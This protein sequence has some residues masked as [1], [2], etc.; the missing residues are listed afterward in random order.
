[1]ISKQRLV[2]LASPDINI[3]HL[4]TSS[5]KLY[6]AIKNLGD[7]SK[8]LINESFPPP[9]QTGY[10]ERFRILG[11]PA[12]NQSNVSLSYNHVIMPIDPT[13]YWTFTQINLIACYFTC[14]IVGTGS[15]TYFDI[16]VSQQKGTTAWKSLF[17]FGMSPNLPI[18]VTSTHNVQ[19]AIGQ[20]FQD[21]LLRIDTLN[22]DG[23]IADFELALVGYY[24]LDE[25]V[26]P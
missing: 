9:P 7:S 4:K 24:G 8:Q 23:T 17:K 20:L 22:V 10:I 2:N 5:P 26:I 18:G 16:K 15:T 3:A 25:V 14:T 13:G 21:D 6:N 19:F 11:T 1:M 12:S